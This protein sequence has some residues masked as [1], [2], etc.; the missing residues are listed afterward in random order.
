MTH[1]N[2]NGDEDVEGGH[3]SG[4]D[5]LVNLDDNTDNENDLDRSK[6]PFPTFAQRL[7]PF[8]KTL[9]CG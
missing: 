8:L 6:H 4:S 7:S 1:K 3:V 5:H 2:V 9:Q